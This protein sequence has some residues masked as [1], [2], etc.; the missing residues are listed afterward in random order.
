[1]YAAV[2]RAS[3]EIFQNI[4]K[5][6][7]NE[8]KTISV[9]SVSNSEKLRLKIISKDSW[10]RQ[11]MCRING[12]QHFRKEKAEDKPLPEWPKPL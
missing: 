10:A 7:Y 1:M 2:T 8:S 12:V 3:G 6:I 11:I 4:D 9:K 5:I